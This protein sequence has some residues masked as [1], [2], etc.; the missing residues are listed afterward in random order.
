MGKAAR[1]VLSIAVAIAVPFVA[2]VIATAIGVSATLSP[3]LFAGTSALIGAGLGAAGAA[4]TG[5]DIGQGALFGG[6]GGGVGGF[7][8]GASAPL[9]GAA[10][11]TGGITAPVDATLQGMLATSQVGGLAPELAAGTSIGASASLGA[12]APSVATATDLAGGTS[13]LDAVSKVPSAIAAKFTDPKTL[14]D[15]T[16]RAGASILTGQLAGSGLSPEEQQ[17]LDAQVA[18]LQNLRQ[19]DQALFK[20]KLETAMGLLGEA[21]Y[22]DP[23]QY[24]MQAS[25]ATKVA[26]AQATREAQRSASMRPGGQGFTAAD[27]RRAGLDTTAKA[28]TAYLQGSESAQRN[29][30]STYT[31]GLNALPAAPTAGLSYSNNLMNMYAA[32]NKRKDELQKQIGGFVGSLTQPQRDP[33]SI[34]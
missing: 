33:A 30:L 31:A 26:G 23:V 32:A 24:G 22:F 29:R 12:T 28:Q 9:Q 14:A 34:G 19:Q 11:A 16:L 7:F 6:I 17:L 1:S 25:N 2:P 4:L 27:E 18:D 21:R 20:T 8:G 3:A 15:L 13:F 10:G 5:T